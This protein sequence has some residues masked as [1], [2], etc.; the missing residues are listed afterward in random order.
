MI[1]PNSVVR[2][3]SEIPPATT[4]GEISLAAA[5]AANAALAVQEVNYVLIPE[6]EFELYGEKSGYY[7]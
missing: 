1:K 5:I 7:V 3:A 2:S 4:D 6:M